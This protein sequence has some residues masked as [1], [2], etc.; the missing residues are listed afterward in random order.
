VRSYALLLAVLISISCHQTA[1][2]AFC[3]AVP[4]GPDDNLRHQLAPYDLAKLNYLGLNYCENL[5]DARVNVTSYTH[6]GY[7]ANNR[8][9][10]HLQFLDDAA[11]LL[12]GLAWEDEY[13]PVVR[14][15]FARRL[16]KGILQAHIPGTKDYYFFRNRSGGKTFL[17]L[18]AKDSSGGRLALSNWGDALEGSLKVGF[19]V[20]REGSW[21]ANEAFTYSDTPTGAGDAAVARNERY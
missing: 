17:I 6:L 4:L 14:L 18:G 19:R 20:R 10:W 2:T 8:D 13:S 5:L 11:R 21:H 16:V 12:E 3:A 7:D 9:A 15:G 1:S